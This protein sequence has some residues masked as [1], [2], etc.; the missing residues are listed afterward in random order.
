M[1]QLSLFGREMGKEDS[2]LNCFYNSKTTLGRC[3][4][5]K[6]AEVCLHDKIPK[7]SKIQ[8]KFRCYYNFWRAKDD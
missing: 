6:G 8:G 1:K 5:S 2:C 7:V 3:L 4:H